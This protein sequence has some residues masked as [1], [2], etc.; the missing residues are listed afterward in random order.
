MSRQTTPQAEVIVYNYKDRAGSSTKSSL[1]SFAPISSDVEVIRLKTSVISISTSKTKSQPAG[2]FQIILAPTYNWLSVLSPGSWLTIHMVKDSYSP[3]VKDIDPNDMRAL[4]MIG[5]IDS[6]RAAVTADQSTG[7]RNTVF[8]VTGRDWGQVFESYLYIDPAAFYQ[9]DDS[10]SSI[11]KL[12]FDTIAGEYWAKDGYSTTTGLMNFILE[13]WGKRSQ[14]DLLAGSGLSGDRYQ[15]L[16]DFILPRELSAVLG[17]SD[18][19]FRVSSLSS[20]KLSELISIK[21]GTLVSKDTYED[22]QETA[23][24]PSPHALIGNNQLWAILHAHSC[25]VVNEIIADLRWEGNRPSFTLYK[26][27]KPF[28]LSPSSGFNPRQLVDLAFSGSGNAK[29]ISSS[30]FNVRQVIIDKDDVISLDAG[31]NWQ[32]RINFIEVLPSQSFITI[33][34][35]KVTSALMPQIKNDS[36]LLDAP[37]FPREGLKPLLFRTEYVPLKD[38]TP[39]VNAIKD[40]LPVIKSWYFD[41]HK[42]LNGTISFIGQSNYIGVGDNIVVDSSV[43]GQ[44]PMVAGQ[45]QL[46]GEASTLV[47]HVESVT[48]SFQVLGDG[49]RTFT[50][51][52]AFVRGVI[53]N[54]DA[55]ALLDESS[56]GIDSRA[57]AL[58]INSEK[59]PNSY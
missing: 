5:R 25:D 36:A 10:L 42:T 30:F 9:K 39:D 56:F 27:V 59:I 41:A 32:D 19:P 14:R 3:G 54:A 12:S 23:G 29:K 33:P 2:T 45:N 51:S 22:Q 1:S 49:S 37:S 13:I 53:G 38:K 17:G 35:D 26:R 8:Y 48:H 43:L 6:V 55:T 31:N 21:S 15:P 44:A 20:S 4:K 47:A 28:S 24:Q 40:W 46:G 11:S 18:S 52:I 34:G 50:T 58:P 16:Q 7:A 57:D